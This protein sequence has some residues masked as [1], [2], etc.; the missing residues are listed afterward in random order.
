M[1]T[2]KIIS[3]KRPGKYP[4]GFY[5][6]FLTEA[7]ERFGFYLINSL[8][9]LYLTKAMAFSD[10]NA[11]T[12]FAAFTALLYITPAV[13]GLI[14]D[15]F[16]G[17]RRTLILGAVLLTSGYYV[18][19]LP[20]HH[21]TYW[22]L[23][24]IVIGTGFFKSMPYT[25]LNQL[26]YKKSQRKKI[27]SAFT[28]YYLS[29]QIGGM[30]PLFVGGFAARYF[31]WHITFLF[32]AI[33]MTIAVATFLF[34]LRTFKDADV[35]KGYQPVK[36]NFWLML[37]IATGVVV[38]AASYLL[39]YTSITK[40]VVWSAVAAILIYLFKKSRSLSKPDRMRLLTAIGLCSVGAI[41]FS[42]Y[43]QQPMSMTLFI[44]RNVNKH[45][46]GLNMPSSSYWIF[47]PVWILLL[48][49]VLSRVYLKLA[50][51]NKDPS[52]PM[53]FGIGLMFMGVGYL[54]LNISTHFANAYAHVS[55]WWIVGSYAFQAT[56]ELLVNALGTAMIA[57][58]T[59]KPLVGVMMGVW[60]ISTAIGGLLAGTLAN[61]TAIPKG[62]YSAVYSLH[63]YGHA[64]S[65]FGFMSIGLGIVFCFAAPFIMRLVQERKSHVHA[66]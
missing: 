8:L 31:G 62:N 36:T 16:L 15:R 21:S 26:F 49:A 59:P 2:Q 44:E 20:F 56:A 25:L 7:W 39:D 55:S 33:G 4:A 46:L 54:V 52:I 34:G 51:L 22:G 12:M 32:G 24:I 64:F 9:I 63:V 66:A 29:I 45:F 53:K 17:Y 23:A 35:A 61:M 14:A 43:Y 47:S 27:D 38:V 30:V 50:N 60:F 28:V 41:F 1:S 42:L 13:G 65:E 11:Y 5:V 57:K 37:L 10:A 58:L 18:L 3:N 19:A 40:I 6:L 48:G